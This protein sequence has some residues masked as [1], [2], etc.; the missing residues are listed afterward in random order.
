AYFFERA[1]VGR[2]SKS[3]SE[4]TAISEEPEPSLPDQALH[5]V[6]DR[7]LGPFGLRRDSSRS[8]FTLGPLRFLPFGDGGREVGHAWPRLCPLAEVR[9]CGQ[10][11]AMGG[12]V[13]CPGDALRPVL[14]PISRHVGLFDQSGCDRRRV[15]AE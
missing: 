9:L 10:R 1:S 11:G 15:N 12:L 7:W 6:F 14:T 13:N 5:K 2:P 3:R 4:K 8:G